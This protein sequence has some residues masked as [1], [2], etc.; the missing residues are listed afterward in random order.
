MASFIADLLKVVIE[1]GNSLDRRAI[2]TRSQVLDN[3][4]VEQKPND[5]N[6][7]DHFVNFLLQW[8]SRADAF[9]EPE[10]EG[11]DHDYDRQDEEHDEAQVVE[12]E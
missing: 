3:G 11:D 7:R 12:G 8:F 10:N 4:W 9:R 5:C 2:Y 6:C 1:A